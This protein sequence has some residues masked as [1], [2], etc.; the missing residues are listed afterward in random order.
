[1]NILKL[2]KVVGQDTDCVKL[3]NKRIVDSSS[4]GLYTMTL[5]ETASGANKVE[6]YN[7]WV[8]TCLGRTLNLDDHTEEVI[9]D[10]LK[11]K[12]L[13]VVLLSEIIMHLHN[14]VIDFT[15]L[16]HYNTYSSENNLP[17][18]DVFH[19]NKVSLKFNTSASGNF[20]VYR[21]EGTTAF[22][23]DNTIVLEFG[24]PFQMIAVLD[25]TK[26]E[27]FKDFFDDQRNSYCYLRY[28]AR[29]H[30]EGSGTFTTYI[31]FNKNV[32]EII[33]NVLAKSVIAGLIIN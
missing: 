10:Y 17:A 23:A 5:L 20:A 19:V 11:L 9:K 1:M 16:K 18:K 27:S 25:R 22:D 29:K 31:D 32:K 7:Y 33:S 4:N 15:R 2:K 14:F 21:V 8:N 13:Q 28:G 26:F 12:W 6:T 24:I 30:G 3:L